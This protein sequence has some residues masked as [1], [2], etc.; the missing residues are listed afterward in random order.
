MKNKALKITLTVVVSIVLVVIMLLA[1]VKIG[2]RILFTSF[3]VNSTT[4][5]K[6]PG[7]SDGLVQQGFTYLED[8]EMFLVTGYMKKDNRSSR[9]YRVD[10][11]GDSQGYVKLRNSNGTSN[12]THAGGI[13]VYGDFVYVAT[14]AKTKESITT[15]EVFKL[16]DVLTKDKANCIGKIDVKMAPAFLY[17]DNE[18]N[19]LY[20][21]NFHKDGTDY[22]SPESHKVTTPNGENNTAM[23]AV[24]D[25]D[26]ANSKGFGLK[27]NNPEYAY[28][29]T[30]MVQGM[31]I[32]GDRLVL[33]TSYALAKSHLYI[34]DFKK[35]NES[36]TGTTTAFGDEIKLYYVDTTS[37]IKDVKAPPMAEELVYLDGKIF[38]MNESASAKYIFGRFTSGNYV[39]AYEID[40]LFN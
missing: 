19:L 16:D 29:I 23:I 15:I 6:V 35:V 40:K 2:E 34:Y 39:H 14:A 10:K 13:A 5:F 33:S 18:K 25:L 31:T 28:S 32:A 4:E 24:Y 27:D 17:V 1:L 9:V 7:V 20:V 3:H 12:T 11:N 30:N 22:T 21:G 38:I 26:K 36:Q 8:K 37:L